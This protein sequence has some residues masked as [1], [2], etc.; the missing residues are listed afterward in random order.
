VRA[1]PEEG[2]GFLRSDRDREWAVIKSLSDGG[3]RLLPE[4]LF[5]DRDGSELGAKTIITEFVEGETLGAAIQASA[6]D[7]LPGYADGLCDLAA[8]I[9]ATDSDPVADAIG[10][11]ADWEEYFVA[12]VQSWRDAEAAHVESLPQVRYLAAWLEAHP[13]PPAPLTLVHGDFQAPNV[14][15]EPDGGYLA[16]D[17]EAA[18]IADPREDLGYFKMVHAVQPPDVIGLDDARF[19]ARYR[20][21]S[22]L[23]ADVV[24]PLT[25]A[26]F[27]I[28]PGGR[29]LA[30]LLQ[31]LRAV[32]AEAPV[33][34]LTAYQIDIVA[35]L[36]ERWTATARA[37][38]PELRAGWTVT[39]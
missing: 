27:S 26:Y 29:L 8:R 38:E 23:G 12:T 7:D 4:T 32:D 6:A 17:W 31:G 13:P 3:S 37:L 18:R 24:N 36:L 9:H 15:I 16:I 22:G 2:Q 20:E 39:A 19:C 5:Y 21:R 30:P 25:L 14:M 33:P 11:P 10:R 34:V 35:T 28:L 1:D